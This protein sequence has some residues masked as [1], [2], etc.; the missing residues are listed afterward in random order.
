VE[1]SGN[2]FLGTYKHPL[3]AKNRL[4]VP[5]KFRDKLTSS[6]V[7]SKGYEGCLEIR[8][9]EQFKVFAEELTA[10]SQ[11]IANNRL[12][13]RQILANAFDVEFD[14]LGRILLPQRTLEMSN[15]TKEAVIIG[16]GDHL[17]I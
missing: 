16:V 8:S 11:K 12:V 17:E 1:G 14:S 5:S 7:I 9:H 15:I 2:V 10:H 13:V 3:D 4:I 6:V